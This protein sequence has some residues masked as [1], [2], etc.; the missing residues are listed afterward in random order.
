VKSFLFPLFLILALVVLVG[1]SNAAEKSNQGSSSN[2][3]S[4]VSQFPTE[5]LVALNE[6][7]EKF[8]KEN[9]NP[10]KVA[11]V[12]LEKGGTFKLALLPE[13][14]PKTVANFEKKVNEGYY[15]GLIFHRVEDWV[16][17]G[18]DPLGNGTGGGEME[19]ELNP[20]SFTP[21]SLG[22][23]RGMDINI[24]NDSQFFINTTDAGWLD[25]Q[26]TN[27]GQ[28]IEGAEAVLNLKVGDKIKSIKIESL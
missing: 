3:Q 9:P 11:A 14:A 10:N 7:I 24:S 21:G 5:K 4:K 8:K 19:T 16:V 17:Q 26:Y 25:N 27:F 23:A 22:V 12:E 2:N 20:R 18:G 28:L 6:S 1:C 15:N 13:I